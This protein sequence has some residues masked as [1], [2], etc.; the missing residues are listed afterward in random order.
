MHS[1]WSGYQPHTGVS[2][3]TAL[4][5]HSPLAPAAVPPIS[6]G[7]DW[8]ASPDHHPVTVLPWQACGAPGRQCKH[9]WTWGGN[10]FFCK[11]T[12][13]QFFPHTWHLLLEPLF[14]GRRNHLSSGVV[15]WAIGI[16]RGS[17]TTSSTWGVAAPG[18]TCCMKW[19][20]PAG[21]II[22]VFVGRQAPTTDPRCLLGVHRWERGR[23]HEQVHGSGCA[24]WEV[25]HHAR[26]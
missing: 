16:V 26:S 20:R 8:V 7:Y 3:F 9:A 15:P 22:L 5:L 6:L 1:P 10:M 12:G 25:C 24:R 17:C 14:F 21:L 23:G 4:T 18:V 19:V 11:G 2:L 13:P